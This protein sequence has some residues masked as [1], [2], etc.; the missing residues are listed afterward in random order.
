MPDGEGTTWL[1]A[2]PVDFHGKPCE[3]RHMA[4]AHGADSDAILEELGRDADA[5][6]ALRS[7]G[8]VG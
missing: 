7:A 1:R 6:A 8:I 2:T 5:I 4:P 3:Q